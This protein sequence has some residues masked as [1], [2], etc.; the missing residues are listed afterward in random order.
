MSDQCPRCGSSYIKVIYYGLPHRLCEDHQCNTLF[1]FWSDLTEKFPFNGFF[2]AYS[3][4]Y[5]PALLKWLFGNFE[6][7]DGDGQ[8]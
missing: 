5:W 7:D 1:G 4:S 8:R 3:G 6:D 2:L